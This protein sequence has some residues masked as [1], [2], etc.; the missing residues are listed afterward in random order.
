MSSRIVQLSEM[1]SQ[2]P[3]DAFLLF[4]LAKEYENDA[5]D[6]MALKFYTELLEKHP[7]YIGLYYHLGKLQERKGDF[8]DALDTFHHG[9]R[10]AKAQDDRHAYNEL[11]GAVAEL[12][13]NF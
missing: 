12:D 2:K 1:L 13:D 6:T 4:A 9:M 3:D 5:D 10:V 11:S 7:E 8:V